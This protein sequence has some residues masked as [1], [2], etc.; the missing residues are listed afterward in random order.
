MPMARLLRA[1]KLFNEAA[2]D[3]KSGLQTIPQLPLELAMVESILEQDTLP[4]S[5]PAVPITQSSPNPEARRV[6]EQPAPVLA[7]AP[8]PFPDTPAATA[9]LAEPVSTPPAEGEQLAMGQVER[10]WDQVLQ[11]V[12]QRNPATQGLLNT[13]CKPVEVNGNE[14]VVTFPFPFLG[15][16]LVDPQRKEEIQESLSDILHARCRIKFVLASEYT[17]RQQAPGAA[18]DPG[19]QQTPASGVPDPISQWAEKHG[20]QAKFIES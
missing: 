10:A 2:T 11:A 16:K 15:E 5:P 3:L 13:G 4:A 18:L 6:A 19:P 7:P 1:I 8:V 17:P 9:G 12:R 20:G 14:I